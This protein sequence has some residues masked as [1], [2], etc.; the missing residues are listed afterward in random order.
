MKLDAGAIGVFSDDIFNTVDR[1]A[2][3]LH[4]ARVQVAPSLKSNRQMRMLNSQSI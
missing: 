2:I 3:I 4:C 1:L